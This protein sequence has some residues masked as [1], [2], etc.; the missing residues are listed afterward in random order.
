MTSNDPVDALRA[1]MEARI[2][3]WSHRKEKPQARPGPVV[4]VSR[5]PGSGGE[6]IAETLSAELALHLYTW[7]IVE[8][9]AKDEHVSTQ[10]VSTL[11]E[12]T[13]SE[14]EDWLAEFQGTHNLSS[15]AYLHDLKRIIFTIASHGSALIL[16]RGANFCLPPEKRIGLYFVAP[17]EVRIRNVMEERALSE[18]Q[19]RED[20]ARQEAEHRRFVKK[21]FDAD[22][23]DPTRYHLVVNTALV[24][25]ESIVRI[26]KAIIEDRTSSP[27]PIT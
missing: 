26:V 19:A 13:R 12:K 9:I 5:E 17:L 3:D 16:G 21:Y 6:S 10:V 11:D 20:I 18:K 4:T 23:H 7:D 1:L 2:Y 27:R 8:Q 24:G 14:L 15:Y 22:I 25:R